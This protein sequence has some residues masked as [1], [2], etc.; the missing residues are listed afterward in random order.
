MRSVILH[1]HIFKNAGMSIEATLDRNFGERFCRFD[2]PDRNG[3]IANGDLV[4]YLN[5]N[6]HI[7]ALSSHHI[8]YP[9]PTVPG[10]FLFDLCFLRDPL[11]RIRSIYDYT[12]EKPLD[13]DPVSELS[14]R[15]DL[16]SFIEQLMAGMPRWCCN[17]QARFLAGSVDSDELL[18]RSDMERAI[19]TL[20]QTSFLGVVDRYEQSLAAGEFFLRTAFPGLRCTAS[21]VNATKGLDGTLAERKRQLRDACGP[22]L[23]GEL[24]DR[25]ALDLE[26]L[27]VARAEVERRFKIAAQ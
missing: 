4:T 2:T 13:G 11:D 15:F 20:L 12:R 1:Y 5:A 21:T 19:R 9:V 27:D 3:Q 17:V 6:T 26:L 24:E 10:F 22:R 23:Y 14:A 7:Q 18:G 25:N 16:G 8:R